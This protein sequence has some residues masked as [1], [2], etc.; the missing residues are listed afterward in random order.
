MHQS[1]HVQESHDISVMPHCKAIIPMHD[2][3]LLHEL[4]NGM[5]SK[6]YGLIDFS[7]ESIDDEPLP[8]PSAFDMWGR[9]FTM[10]E[11]CC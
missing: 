6:K 2:I 9:G 11:L 4:G 7:Y 10:H 1:R 8:F 3:Q 5:T